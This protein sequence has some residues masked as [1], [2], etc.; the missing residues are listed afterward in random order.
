MRTAGDS[1]LTTTSVR[2][3]AMVGGTGEVR[4][5]GEQGCIEMLKGI[6]YPCTWAQVFLFPPLPTPTSSPLEGTQH[7]R[8]WSTPHITPEVVT[9]PG[10][11]T[12]SKTH[13]PQELTVDG[14]EEDLACLS[15]SVGGDALKP[16]LVPGTGT[17]DEQRP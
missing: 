14:H 15:G 5:G 16:P 17:G 3:S 12:L 4:E 8:G 2:S 10:K 7:W 1:Q 9:D 13:S 11:A 6:P